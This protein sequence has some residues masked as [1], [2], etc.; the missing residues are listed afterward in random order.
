MDAAAEIERNPASKHRF[1]LS[2]E[3][4]QAD[5]GRDYRTRLTRPNSQARTG[6]GKKSFSCPADHE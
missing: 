1:S 2:I 3:N 6:P 5:V 4:E